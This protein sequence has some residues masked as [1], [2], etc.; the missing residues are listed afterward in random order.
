MTRTDQQLL[1]EIVA[2]CPQ[3]AQTVTA[4]FLAALTITPT[5]KVDE[6]LERLRGERLVTRSEAGWAPTDAG[7]AAV[8]DG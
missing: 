2:R 8:Q 6:A 1:A 4:A 7:R 3:H 5:A